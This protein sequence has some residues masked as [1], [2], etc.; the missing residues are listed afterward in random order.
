MEN[1]PLKLNSA[2]DASSPLK[3]SKLN[4]SSMENSPLAIS[5]TTAV[6]DTATE[7]IEIV[8]EPIIPTGSYDLSKI[9]MSQAEAPKEQDLTS[10]SLPDRLS[11]KQ[12]K[13]RVHG[14]EELLQEFQNAG[15]STTPFKEHAAIVLTAIKTEKMTKTICVAME[16]VKAYVEFAPAPSCLELLGTTES[17]V[18][19]I[20]KLTFAQNKLCLTKAYE[21]IFILIEKMEESETIKLIHLSE[22]KALNTAA[23][24]DFSDWLSKAV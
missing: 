8:P 6:V 24:N 7:N 10:I 9:D 13:H 15:T 5:K 2:N 11:S 14:Y 22:L 21:A 23:Y 18:H 20:V 3:S 17:L 12:W 16:L 1:S 4:A 19:S